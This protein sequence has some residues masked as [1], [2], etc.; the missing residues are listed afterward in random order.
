LW[1]LIIG[2][3]LPH[4]ANQTGWITAEVGRQPW[5]VYGLLKTSDAIS[6]TVSSGSVWFSLILFT[7]IYVLIFILFIFL[8]NRKI[9]QGITE[10][11]ETDIYS[12]QKAIFE[13][14]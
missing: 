6:K 11:A 10:T 4:I 3:V 9:K 1:I 12:K 2:V 8:L 14:Q 7:A 5:I 13:K